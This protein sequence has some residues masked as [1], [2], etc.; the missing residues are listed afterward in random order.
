MSGGLTMQDIFYGSLK[1]LHM[2]NR[3]DLQLSLHTPEEEVSAITQSVNKLVMES[4]EI[5]EI[6]LSMNNKEA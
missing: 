6:L 4:S 3:Y 5:K 1:E 2:T